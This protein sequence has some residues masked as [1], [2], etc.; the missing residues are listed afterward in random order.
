MLFRTLLLAPVVA[1][2]ISAPGHAQT[3]PL[4]AGMESD[5]IAVGTG[6]EAR[7]G[8]SVT[9]HYTGWFSIDGIR[10]KRFDSSRGSE[11]FTFDLGRGDVIKGWDVGIVGMKVGGIRSLLI[12]PAVGYGAQGDDTIPPDSWLLFEVELLK[13]R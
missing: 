12:P 9:V 3:T 10:G 8:Q 13:V 7:K 4:P 5:D 6:A 2:S 1:L 11:P